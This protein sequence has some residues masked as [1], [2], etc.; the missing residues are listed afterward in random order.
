MKDKKQDAL[1]I[2]DNEN[3]D[4]KL[5]FNTCDSYSERMVLATLL[6]LLRE[7]TKKN[8]GLPGY[9]QCLPQEVYSMLFSSLMENITAS[10]Y[11]K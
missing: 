8:F 6:N 9:C 2:F 11:H 5:L 1:N 10:N 3:P 4:F 7:K